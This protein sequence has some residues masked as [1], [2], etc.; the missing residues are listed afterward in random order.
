MIAFKDGY[1]FALNCCQDKGKHASPQNFALNYCH[2]IKALDPLI[3]FPRLSFLLLL[4]FSTKPKKSSL[5][6]LASTKGLTIVFKIAKTSSSSSS[7][8]SYRQASTNFWPD[9]DLNGFNQ[10]WSTIN[11]FNNFKFWVWVS[12][13]EGILRVCTIFIKNHLW[14]WVSDSN[15]RPGTDPNSATMH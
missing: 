12:T 10:R 15:L 8:I 2:G 1:N 5:E 13:V 4:K 14:V 7:T 3:N 11:D 9:P 6:T